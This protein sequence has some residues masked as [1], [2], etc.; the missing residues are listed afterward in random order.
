MPI[1]D[2]LK[3]DE[4]YLAH[5]DGKSKDGVLKNPETIEEHS[6]LTLDYAKKII[7]VQLSLIHI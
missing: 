6:S 7:E 1:S 5:K 3:N 4:N 2:Y